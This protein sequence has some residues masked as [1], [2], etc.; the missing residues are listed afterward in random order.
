MLD[1]VT[2]VEQGKVA[3]MI[4][5]PQGRVDGQNYQELIS[6]A[7]DVYQ[8]GARDILLDMSEVPY[9]SSAGVMAL[10]SIALL[11]D[12]APL[13]NIDNAWRMLK[14]TSMAPRAGAEKHLKLLHVQ[15]EVRYVL[16]ILGMTAHL[17]LFDDRQAAL[18]AF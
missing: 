14:K 15:P 1:I 12:G 16:D 10:Q 4:L 13:P 9:I 5:R 2:S 11:L 6:K 18:N 8:S 3:V 17:D 7:A